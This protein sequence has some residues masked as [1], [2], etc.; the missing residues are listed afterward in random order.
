M[1]SI[2]EQLSRKIKAATGIWRLFLWLIV[3]VWALTGIGIIAT[4]AWPAALFF[5]IG[6]AYGGYRLSK[7]DQ[8]NFVAKQDV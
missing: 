8:P 3:V 7:G 5:I 2:K 4:Y 6:A 1:R